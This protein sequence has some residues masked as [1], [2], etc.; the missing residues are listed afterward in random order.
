MNLKKTLSVVGLCLALSAGFFAQPA[1]RFETDF[2]IWN[3]TQFIVPLD[4]K[5]DWNLVLSAVGRFGDNA[6][7]TT[8]ARGGVMLTKRVS[9][10][11]TVGGGYLYRFSNPTF[12]QKR[13]ESRYLGVATFTVPL[14]EK[15]ALV[16][17]NLVQYEDRYS[18]PN[19]TV[20]RNRAWLRREI[21]VAKTKIEPF[22]SFETFYDFRSKSFARFRT[23]AGVTRRFNDKFSADFFYVRQDETGD[24]AR[25]GTLNGVG[26]NFR[27]NL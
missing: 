24:G 25:P 10:Y 9:K 17:R 4:E 12:R 5:K 15:W 18:R 22:V 14:G 7:R 20:L 27:V 13:F 6:R 23:Q 19:T 16:N 11:A 8:D 3:E 2:Q 1:E 21:T 26:T